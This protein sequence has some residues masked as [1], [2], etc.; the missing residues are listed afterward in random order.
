MKIDYNELE[1]RVY[2]LLEEKK[3]MVLATSYK[4]K[5]T[6]RSMSCIMHDKKIY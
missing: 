2:K 3:I 5:V 1:N 4:D 6:A